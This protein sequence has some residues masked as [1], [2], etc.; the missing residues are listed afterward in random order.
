MPM[1][2][3]QLSYWKNQET[4]RSNRAREALEGADLKERQRSNLVNEALNLA[5]NDI[6]FQKMIAQYGKSAWD[7]VPTEWQ[8]ELANRLGHG[9]FG[10]AKGYDQS[11][12]SEIWYEISNKF[13]KFIQSVGSL[14]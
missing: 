3:N 11:F 4:E 12:W 10:D 2:S 8:D 14:F 6:E 5:R 1:T 7:Q 13:P 9:D